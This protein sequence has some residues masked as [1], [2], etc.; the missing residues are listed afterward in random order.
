MENAPQH[1]RQEGG[2][3]AVQEI[4]AVRNKV[5]ILLAIE[6]A[7]EAHPDLGEREIKAVAMREWVGD[8]PDNPDSLAAHFGEYVEKHEHEQCDLSN[9]T[10][11]KNLLEKVRNYKPD[12]L[13]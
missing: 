12:T 10:A 3:P 13:H 8:N 2:V 4:A 11:L 9:P 5:Q 7:K 6:A 1:N